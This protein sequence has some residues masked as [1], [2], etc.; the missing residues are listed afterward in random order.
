M[1]Y[2]A[3]Q[4]LSDGVHLNR[5]GNY[6]YI[7]PSQEQSA[8]TGQLYVQHTKAGNPIRCIMLCLI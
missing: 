2:I 6:K 3:K 1:T 5:D 4:F 8:H 7:N